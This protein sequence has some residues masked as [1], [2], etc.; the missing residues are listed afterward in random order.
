MLENS[1]TIEKLQEDVLY[2]NDFDCASAVKA[3][4]KEVMYFHGSPIDPRKVTELASLLDVRE[5]FEERGFWEFYKR[6]PKKDEPKA[7]LLAEKMFCW[8]QLIFCLFVL[9]KV[10][11]AFGSTQPPD[12]MKNHNVACVVGC[13]L[14]HW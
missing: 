6:T 5:D 9:T 7:F 10:G 1:T 12:T 8:L 14:L 11:S 4:E 2:W 13:F 3:Q